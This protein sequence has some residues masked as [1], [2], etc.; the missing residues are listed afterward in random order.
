MEL[1]LLEDNNS[2]NY[3]IKDKTEKNIYSTDTKNVN[4]PCKENKIKL[5]KFLDYKQDFEKLS[6]TNPSLN[7]FIYRK[8]NKT[9]LD[10]RKENCLLEL[11]KALFKDKYNIN[12]WN[13]PTNGFL[14]PC[15]NSRESYLDWM[16]VLVECSIF[17]NYYNI[18]DVAIDIGTGCSLVYPLIGYSKFNFKFVGLEINS[19]SIENCNEIIKYNNLESKIYIIKNKKNTIFRELNKLIEKSKNL[20]TCFSCIFFSSI[21]ESQNCKCNLKNNNNNII[22][23]S[24]CNPPYFRYCKDQNINKF[25][26]FNN[27]EVVYEGGEEEFIKL[28]I[29][30]SYL[31][32]D[33]VLWFSTL[34]GTHKT[35]NDIKKFILNK[36]INKNISN[37]ENTD[38]IKIM[39]DNTLKTGNQSRWAIAWSFFDIKIDVKK[40]SIYK[41]NNNNYYK[42]IKEANNIV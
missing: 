4:S 31:L 35:Y 29:K 25:C 32:K 1:K 8:H 3:S 37:D 20:K 39:L 40:Y 6:I 11:N 42:F 2:S 24:I 30:E 18:K 17:D 22:S 21:K 19:K 13:M 14:I 28:I 5:T 16:Y 36:I 12:Y 41:T 10:F 38:N 34:I 23:F 9:F 15:L 33:K 27:D 26:S 7:E